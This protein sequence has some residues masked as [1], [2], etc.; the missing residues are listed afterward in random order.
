MS[1]RFVKWTCQEFGEAL[2]AFPFISSTVITGVH[3]H[4]T[5][6]PNHAQW[7]GASTVEAMWRH[8]TIVNNWSD[9]AQHITIDPSGAIW[10][11]RGWE[12]APASASGCNGTSKRHPFMFE[13][14]GDFDT[15]RDRFDGLQKAAAIEVIAQVQLL[16]KLPLESLRF[17]NQMSDKTCPGTSIVYHDVLSAVKATRAG[18]ELGSRYITP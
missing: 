6:R 12:K 17:H 4:H 14:V 9:I 3:M 15:G 1:K 5:Y 2:R 8:H 13:M 18:F 7:K 16:F 10:S 11:G